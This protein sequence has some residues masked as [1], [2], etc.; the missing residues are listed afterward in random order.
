MRV[1]FFGLFLW[2]SLM[3]SWPKLV[4]SVL[5]VIDFIRFYRFY[6]FYVSLGDIWCCL[7]Y[8]IYRLVTCSY[9]LISCMFLAWYRLLSL[10]LLL[11]VCAHDT[12][13]DA[14]L[15]FS[16]IDT[17]VLIFA[18]HL[19]FASPLVGEFCLPWIL[20]SRSWSLERVDS[21]SCW[22]EKCSSS[23]DLLQTVQSPILPTPLC[24]SRVFLL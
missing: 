11:H 22:P 8:F 16:F 20:M 6:R 19:S 4:R 17:R 12:V 21:P 18:R 23:V 5:L 7:I 9:H 2:C 15:W 14:W 3:E 1:S 24:V 10:Y 13:F